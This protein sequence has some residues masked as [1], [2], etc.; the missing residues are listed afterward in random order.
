MN[1]GDQVTVP[2]AKGTK[3]GVVVRVCEKSVWVKVDFPR[4]PGKLIRRKLSQVESKAPK[5]RARRT[6]KA[7]STS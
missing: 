7:E 4:H 3:E 2:F 5:K 1:I 6:K